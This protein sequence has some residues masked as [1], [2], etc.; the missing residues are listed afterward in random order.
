MIPSNN[1]NTTGNI[2]I[3]SEEECSVEELSTVEKDL[4]KKVYSE[5]RNLVSS[6]KPRRQQSVLIGQVANALALQHTGIFEAP[7]GTGKTMGYLIPGIV[8]SILRKKNLIIST[9]TTSLQDQVANKDVP[10]L[11]KAL[12]AAGLNE[13]FTYAVAKG[14]ER[15]LCVTKLKQSCSQD[16]LFDQTDKPFQSEILELEK[17]WNKSGWNGIRDGLDIRPIVWNTVKNTA[18]TCS[19][20]TCPDYETCPYYINNK[21][22]ESASLIITNHDY[23]LSSFVHNENS[24]VCKTETNLYV[25]D[26]AHHLSDK[27][28]QAFK[29]EII[30]ANDAST[31]IYALLNAMG[32]GES[33]VKATITSIEKNQE[34]IKNRA[35]EL[36]KGDSQYIFDFGVSDTEI[37]ATLEEMRNSYKMLYEKIEV[38]YK[39]KKGTFQKNIEQQIEIMFKATLSVIENTLKCIEYY[40]T[41][42][43][44]KARWISESTYGLIKLYC[45]PFDASVLA[46]MYLWNKMKSVVFTSA[47]LTSLGTFES[48]K[49]NLGLS[50][51]SHTLQ[52]DSP[53]DY[54]RTELIV[55][56]NCVVGNDKRH[57]QDSIPLIK[58]LIFDCD[59]IKGIL[60]Y[61]TSRQQ[62][63]STYNAFT[64]KQQKQILMQDGSSPTSIV[65]QHKKNIDNQ[66]K[67]I[68]FGLDS[69]SEGLDLPGD[70][71][72]RVII[73]KIPFPQFNDP[74]L[75]THA[76]ILERD[77]TAAF[78]A[79]LLPKA[80]QKMAQVVGRLIRQEG[81]YG[82]VFVLDKRMT[83]SR[84][85]SQL[86]KGTPYQSISSNAVV[87]N[88]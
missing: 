86:L 37:T 56:S 52:L 48:F 31:E 59:E 8:L 74:I 83:D 38:S 85:G 82:D 21:E 7:T 62:M 45:S 23:I 25:F 16:E 88:K 75:S 4:I 79:I 34:Q 42:N 17:K 41:E 69:I 76:K 81:D 27:C 63:E 53:L 87:I 2:E 44:E 46:K 15:Y 19:G 35:R 28:I 40:L 43:V 6:S 65:E 67:S 11:A 47:T 26:E 57:S 3:N 49:R 20:K 36:L 51:N 80:S 30:L 13:P 64:K 5:F 71:C 10:L 39:V 55:P 14:R 22:I 78:S 9:A 50:K 68:I 1:S 54:S 72:T 70:Y 77:G 58:S 84:Y 61:F 73:A 24:K 66:K 29:R 33:S 12:A 32:S 18:A 60:V